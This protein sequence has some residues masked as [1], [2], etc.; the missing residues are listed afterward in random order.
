MKNL[1]IL[2]GTLLG[3]ACPKGFATYEKFVSQ[4]VYAANPANTHCQSNQVHFSDTVSSLNANYGQNVQTV[5]VAEPH[6]G[7]HNQVV[8]FVGAN[9]V[10]QKQVNVV[11]RKGILKTVAIKKANQARVNC[12]RVVVNK[13]NQVVA[14]RVVRTRLFE[15]RFVGPV[16]RA[17]FGEVSACRAFSH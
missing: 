6:W 7:S 2:I 3:L 13:H 8:Q 10:A 9:H 4:V 1:F 11:V 5:V 16:R 15:G 17:L 12:V 14:K